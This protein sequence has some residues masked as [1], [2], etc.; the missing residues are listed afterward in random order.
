[1]GNSI[2]GERITLA[3]FDS[4]HLNDPSY[5]EW[6]NDIAVMRH[7]GREEYLK[8]V[9]FETAKTYVEQTLSNPYCHFYAIHLNEG[10]E[11]IGTAKINYKDSAG[12][13]IHTADI[14]IMIGNRDYWNKGLAIE[15]LHLV[16]RYAFDVLGARKLTAGG[17]AEN[18]SILRAFRRIGFHEEGRMRKSVRIAGQYH[19]HVLFGCFPEELVS[20][21]CAQ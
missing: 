7:I 1:M 12:Q 17:I 6:L 20:L 19:D 21:K 10:Q 15:T 18:T 11:F 2:P 3:P 16:C 9:D 13:A 5:L 4:R 8:P 14:G